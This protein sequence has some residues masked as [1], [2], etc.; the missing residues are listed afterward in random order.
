M[1]TIPTHIS[2][3]RIAAGS[4]WRRHGCGAGALTHISAPGDPGISDGIAG[5]TPEDGDGAATGAGDRGWVDLVTGVSAEAV[6]APTGAA[7]AAAAFTAGVAFAAAASVVGAASAAAAS[8][9]GVASA[10]AVSMAGVALGEAAST[11]AAEA[12]MVAVATAKY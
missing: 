11:A 9:V 8:M 6:A 5:S 7:S 4:G 12:V 10:E 3:T 1:T 2:T